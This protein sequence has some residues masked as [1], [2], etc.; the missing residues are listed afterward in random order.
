[1]RNQPFGDMGNYFPSSNT[2]LIKYNPEKS[3]AQLMDSGE[4]YGWSLLN[5]RQRKRNEKSQRSNKKSNQVVS[6][7]HSKDVLFVLFCFSSRA[8]ESLLTVLNKEVT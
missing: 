1:M 6:L 5:K 3:L 8:L 7:G 2:N 4:H